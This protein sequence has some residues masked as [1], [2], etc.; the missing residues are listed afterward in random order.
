VNL[1]DTDPIERNLPM[2]DLPQIDD[3]LTGD[4]GS[5]GN[6]I[7]ANLRTTGYWPVRTQKV[8]FKGRDIWVLPLMA[9]FYPAVATRMA[10]GESRRDALKDLNRFLSVLSWVEQHGITVAFVGGGSRPR[11]MGR[12]KARGFSA[13]KEFNLAYVPEPTETRPQLALALMREGRSLNHPAYSFLS[14]YR[15]LEVAIPDVKMRKT[16][17][18]DAVGRISGGGFKHRTKIIVDQ[19]RSSGIKLFETHL[20]ET[21]RQA[22]AHGSREPIVDPDDPAQ[23]ERMDAEMPLIHDLAELAIEEQFGIETH[24]TSYRK[25]LY[26]LSGFKEI[27]GPDA[28]TRIAAAEDPPN[29]DNTELPTIDVRIRT[30]EPYAILRDMEPRE[31]WQDGKV[32][33]LIFDSSDRRGM[34]HLLLDF[35]HERLQ[36]DFL[37]DLTYRDD[38]T[39]AA[40]EGAAEIQRFMI[41]YIGNGELQIYNSETGALISRKDAFLPVN[42]MPDPEGSRRMISQWLAKADWRRKRRAE[43]ENEIL[44]ADEHWH[45]SLAVTFDEIQGL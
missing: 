44:Q 3:V 23:T 39:A 12:E 29:D 7:V 34:L 30:R 5:H 20:R 40:A 24:T 1:A 27:L 9:N 35:P 25:H 19:L 42:M 33:N 8:F 18:E 6:W 16:W 36:F 22:V 11:P 2:P 32:V 13:V 41:D 37:A 26:E 10:P 14:Y 17:I 21:N 31:A 45:I 43:V 28:L 15:I 38:G 4:L